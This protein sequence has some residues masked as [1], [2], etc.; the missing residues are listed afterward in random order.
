[1]PNPSQKTSSGNTFAQLKNYNHPK[2]GYVNS[3]K[4]GPFIRSAYGGVGNLSKTKAYQND[5]SYATLTQAYTYQNG[6]NPKN[7]R[8]CY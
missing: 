4:T 1:M 2:P 7:G 8:T 6:C 5:G 3:E